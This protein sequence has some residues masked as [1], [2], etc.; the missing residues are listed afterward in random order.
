MPPSCH[1][2]YS[3]QNQMDAIAAYAARRGMRIV[4][5]YSDEGR[6]GLNID[7][8]AALRECRRSITPIKSG[9][10]KRMRLLSH[11][12]IYTTPFSAEL[13]MNSATKARPVSS[14]SILPKRPGIR[15][16]SGKLLAFEAGIG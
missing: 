5:T 4:R 8:R 7:G 9:P 6:S 14:C 12:F 2:Q 3:T 16:Q 13:L 1:G 11:R 10:S 15:W